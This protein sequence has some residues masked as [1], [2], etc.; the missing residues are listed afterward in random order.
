M[1]GTQADAYTAWWGDVDDWNGS[2]GTDD[3]AAIQA[4]ISAMTRGNC[5][6]LGS[7]HKIT[8]AL[9][10]TQTQN[11]VNLI[12]ASYGSTVF[13]GRPTYLISTSTSADFLDITG[14]ALTPTGA[15]YNRIE[16]LS[17]QR[18]A[19]PTGSA[20]GI[21]LTNAG[22]TQIKNVQI[23]DSID[24]LSIVTSSAFGVGVIEDVSTGF[25]GY[26]GFLGRQ[27]ELITGLLQILRAQEQAPRFSLAGYLFPPMALAPRPL[28]DTT[29]PE[30]I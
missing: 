6:V 30:T 13:S 28:G 10:I 17:F 22:G 4:C 19:A 9:S 23:S 21:S 25:R 29:L 27:R 5:R 11:N 7:G 3:T 2:T 15:S 12:G 16:N 26:H 8:S 1:A 18:S 24:N 20:K 14:S